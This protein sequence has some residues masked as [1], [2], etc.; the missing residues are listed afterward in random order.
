MKKVGKYLLF[1]GIGIFALPMIG[2][3]WKFMELFM[4]HEMVVGI[5]SAVVGAAMI[6]L[7]KA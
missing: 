5:G 4:G 6:F 7:G 2:L 3:E 1:F